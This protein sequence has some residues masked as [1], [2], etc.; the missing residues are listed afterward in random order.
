MSIG[1]AALAHLPALQMLIPLLAAPVCA[2]I[3]SGAVARVTALGAFLLCL[4]CALSLTAPFFSGEAA[5]TLFYS[6]GGWEPPAG[7]NFAITSA[8]GV[9]LLILSFAAAAVALHLLVSAE[10]AERAP[11]FSCLLLLCYAGLAGMA[12]TYDIFNFYVFLE[13]SSLA[14]YALIALGR[15]RRALVASYEYL[16]L[17]SAGA[18]FLLVGIAL[19]YVLTGS[20]NMEDISARLPRGEED[21]LIGASLA[22]IT[23][24]MLM[25]IAAPPLHL[26]LVNSY[27]NATSATA[28]F[29]AATATKIAL[30]MLI[31]MLYVVYGG[32]TALERFYLS[33]LLGY[34]GVICLL[35]GAYMAAMQHNVKRILA[36]SSISWIGYILIALSFHDNTALALAF[37]IIVHHAI[38]KCALLLCADYLEKRFGGIRLSNL[39]G[40]YGAAP[41]AAGVMTLL[42]LS[43]AGAPGFSG[44]AV[45]WELL[46]YLARNGAW[47]MLA[48][49]AA[50]SLLAFFYIWRL[51]ETFWFEEPQSR[52][53]EGVSA[54]SCTIALALCGLAASLWFGLAS[55]SLKNIGKIA[56]DAFF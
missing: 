31:K 10:G 46:A 33:E 49:V 28:A 44:F 16:I 2:V 14:A 40:A 29:L 6:F 50:G 8:T 12:M 18:C 52:R 25:K 45:K 4:C 26:W 37:M 20:L 3:R 47:V 54:S 32:E 42:C 23:V 56:A 53:P 34:A 9:F 13:I 27:T 15:D 38:V 36:Y 35:L 22:F 1:N 43:L 39:R 7:I 51:V 55:G 11:V 21:A 17:G 48:A 5:E 19:L 30:F 41:F 24:G